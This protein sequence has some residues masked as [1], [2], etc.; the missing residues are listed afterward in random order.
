MVLPPVFKEFKAITYG[1]YFRLDLA[2]VS[3]LSV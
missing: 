3:E 2:T 1:M